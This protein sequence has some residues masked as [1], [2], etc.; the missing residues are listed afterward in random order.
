MSTTNFYSRLYNMGLAAGS[1]VGDIHRFRRVDRDGFNRLDNPDV[2]FFKLLFYFHNNDM[3]VGDSRIGDFY[4]GGDCGLLAPT[5]NEPGIPRLMGSDEDVNS[6]QSTEY[7]MYNTA[8]AY[9]MNNYELE[10]AN[11]LREFITLLSQISTE[12]PWY[13]QEISGVDE[14]LTREKFTISEERRKISIKCLNDPVDRR[15][16]RLLSLYRSIVWSHARKCEVLPAN[17]RKFDMG[18]FIYSGAVQGLNFFKVPKPSGID[19]WKNLKASD[20]IKMGG[21]PEDV[22]WSDINDKSTQS[23]LTIPEGASEQE[24]KLK[25]AEW[26]SNLT[27]N[28][29]YIEFHNCEISM[30]SI[31]SGYGS[32]SNAEGFGQEFT[33]DIYFDDCYENE[34][35][36]EFLHQLGDF[37]VW[38]LWSAQRNENTGEAIGDPAS[39]QPWWIWDNSDE[40][41]ESN[42]GEPGI[43]DSLKDEAL[44]RWNTVKQQATAAFNGALDDIKSS[45]LSA[46]TGGLGN[47]YGQGGGIKGALDSVQ[48]EASKQLKSIQ[49][50]LVGNINNLTTNASRSL[51]KAVTAPINGITKGL[52][53]IADTAIEAADNVIAKPVLGSMKAA[54]TA[55]VRATEAGLSYINEK[56][57]Y[58]SRESEK[59]GNMAYDKQVQ[60]ANTIGKNRLNSK[61]GNM[62]K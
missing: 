42:S 58:I 23:P 52:G 36:R 47:F 40:T 19:G 57:D 59:I 26:N 48:S 56:G 54:E 1:S 15:I 8:W 22:F 5:W 35:Y 33:I 31:K 41:P 44:G 61:L 28:Y 45:A 53:K 24:R 62:N 46:V 51:T 50:K 34:Y 9:L 14:A 29:K 39:V 55:S 18:L 37:F 4:S 10:R 30:D 43:W 25:E 2:R 21:T 3:N 38:D 32:M 17:L 20:L 7:Y 13:F 60:A 27:A 6:E 11:C 12:S 49:N 16:E